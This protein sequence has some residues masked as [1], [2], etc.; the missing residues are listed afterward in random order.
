MRRRE[1]IT[2]LGGA[3]TVW[4]LAALAQQPASGRR[5]LGILF[6]TSARAAQAHGLLDAIVQGLKE[7]GWI[8]GQNFT[9]EYRFANG[10][11]DVL[12]KLAAELVQSGLD[13]ILADGA[14]ATQAARSAT[15]T[16]PIVAVTNDP[17]ESDLVASV[18]RPG[19]NITGVSLLAPQLFAG[20]RLQL[21]TEVV[22]GPPLAA[23]LLNPFNP[24][25]EL[26]LDQTQTAAQLLG[27]E[28]HAAEA[29]APDKLESAFGTITATRA[30]ALIVLPDA[31][32]FAQ[33]PRVVAYAA[34]R[35]GGLL[36][37]SNTAAIRG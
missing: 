34:I 23:I 37:R 26:I 7:R 27:V 13:V 35:T 9:F 11:E 6:G 18:N 1:F 25:H 32:L 3:A 17:V 19:G 36:R 4:P 8:E 29:S 14:R 15:G 22:P 16:V 24:I 20:R 5:R 21:L 2:L 12:P 30:G 28:V 31:M 10:K 33:Y